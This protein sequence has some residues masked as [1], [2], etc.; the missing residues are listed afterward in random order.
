MS[1]KLLISICAVVVFIVFITFTVLKQPEKF[2][3]NN[4]VPK[5]I[6]LIYIPWDKNQKLKESQ[7]DQTKTYMI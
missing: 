3:Y 2:R 7:S 5:I 4:D 1:F 6:H